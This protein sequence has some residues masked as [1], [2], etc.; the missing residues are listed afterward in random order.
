MITLSFPIMISILVHSLYY[1]VDSVY[2]SWVLLILGFL[3]TL[4]FIM[5]LTQRQSN[6]DNEYVNIVFTDIFL[7][8]IIQQRLQST[9]CIFASM[10]AQFI[11]AIVYLI[12]ELILIFPKW[13]LLVML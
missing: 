12:W 4:S 8:I 13:V 3:G 11:V 7:E 10:M 9:G 2:C 5:Q 6:G 1:R